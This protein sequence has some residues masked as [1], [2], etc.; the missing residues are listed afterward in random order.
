[1][2]PREGMDPAGVAYDE[3]NLPNIFH[4]HPSDKQ[5]FLSTKTD[6]DYDCIYYG[7]TTDRPTAD[8]PLKAEVE[9]LKNHRTKLQAQVATLTTQVTTL[10][11]Q[12]A[13]LTTQFNTLTTQVDTF[14]TTQATAVPGE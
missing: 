14:S 10:T 6:F 2:F 9:E 13:T 1:M 8:G 4:I 12:V 11:T 7:S 3:R 5:I